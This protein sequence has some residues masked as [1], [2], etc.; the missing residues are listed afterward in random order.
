[1]RYFHYLSGLQQENVFYQK[2]KPVTKEAPKKL[3]EQALGAVL[4]MPAT[5]HDIAA[6]ITNQKYED[7]S[8]VVFCLEDAVGDDE[9]KQAEHNL[10]H[11]LER[12]DQAVQQRKQLAE[13]FPFM[14]VRVRSP[15]QLKTLADMLPHSLHLLT[16]FVFPKCS[17]EN[18]N[19]YFEALQ[20]VSQ[21]YGT[22]LYGMPILETPDVLSKKTRMDVLSELHMI[23]QQNKDVI[24]NVRIGATDLC[25]LY[26]IRR[27]PDQSIYDIRLIADFM[28]DI[29]NYF[30]ADFT[31][32][33]P[34][35]E[36]F[37][38]S[39]K[40]APHPFH[41]ASDFSEYMEGLVKETTLDIANGIHGKTVI[42]PTQ[43]KVV[44]SL[45]VV[46]QE[47]YT[48]ALHI[49]HHAKGTLGVLKSNFSNKM[50]EMKPHM[51]WAETILLKSDI[52]GV[53]HENRHFTDLLTEQPNAA[54][55]GQYGG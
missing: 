44:N 33:G 20:E 6:V 54:H 29:I 7:L 4:Y 55:Y 10:K 45:Y 25:G 2:P 52:Y 5:R 21:Q 53:F 15:Q 17:I 35:W 3:L 50:N 47:D 37:D 40:A 48:D 43:L 19:L 39:L 27:K 34:V 49:A 11:Q 32:S 22:V 12:I 24:L 1:M 42:H 28:A 16:G 23:F 41:Q 9:V 38:P 46:S 18:A 36:Y 31:I 8:S 26:G 14:F 51:K 13:H 30:G